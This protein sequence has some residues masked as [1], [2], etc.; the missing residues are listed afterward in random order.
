LWYVSFGLACYRICAASY[1]KENFGSRGVRMRGGGYMLLLLQIAVILLQPALPFGSGARYNDLYNT[2]YR[3]FVRMRGGSTNSLNWSEFFD[4]ELFDRIKADIGYNEDEKAVAY[5]CY[6][7]QLEYNDIATLDGYLGFYS[8][9]YKEAWRQVIA[10]ALDLQPASAAY[11]DNSG[12]RCYMYSGT[13]EAIPMYTKNLGGISTE[14]LYADTGALKNMGCK[15]IFSR[16]GFSN[17]AEKNLTMIGEYQGKAY[18][19]IVYEL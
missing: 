19:I 4:T 11:F 2:A 12:I 13:E 10:P 5:G 1:R 15:Y 17:A 16:I 6:P 3:E 18:R 14:P 8:Q 7:A 9:K